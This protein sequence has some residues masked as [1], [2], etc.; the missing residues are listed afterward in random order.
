MNCR[1]SA[2][3]LRV[4]AFA[5]GRDSLVAPCRLHAPLAALRHAGFIADC[6]VTDATLR[7]APRDG[8]FDVV[9][10]QRGAD[11]WPARLPAQRRRQSPL[12]G[13]FRLDRFL[14]SA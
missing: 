7:G 11:A 6:V 12:A 1:S 10:L 4:L 8:L 13:P 2:A 9:W 14:R 3:G 5:D